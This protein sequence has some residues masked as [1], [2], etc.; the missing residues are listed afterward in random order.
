MSNVPNSP[1]RVPA[2]QP[3]G[4]DN[5]LPLHWAIVLGVAVPAGCFVG[6]TENWG[7]GILV[8][9]TT[10]VGL[11]QLLGRGSRS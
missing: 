10:A 6:T 4:A 9:V 8:M 5:S 3:D 2:E 11:H 7:T 1:G